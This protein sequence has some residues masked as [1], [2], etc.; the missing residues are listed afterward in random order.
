MPKIVEGVPPAPDSLDSST[1]I[2]DEFDLTLVP[3]DNLSNQEGEM[4][5][6][7]LCERNSESAKSDNTDAPS[8]AASVASNDGQSGNHHPGTRV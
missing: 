6:D 7:S 4:P 8:T 5:V 3:N 2:D 1:G